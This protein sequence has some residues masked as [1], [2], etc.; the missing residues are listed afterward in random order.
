MPLLFKHYPSSESQIAVWHVQESTDE[1]RELLNDPTE[2]DALIS[3]I[4]LESRRSEK[5]AV[6]LLLQKML[7][8]E[9]S[10][11]SYDF[12]GRPTLIG[13]QEV[14]ISHSK[15]LVSVFLHKKKRIGLD[16]E[17]LRGLALRLYSKFA[18]DIEKE[19]IDLLKT[20]EER[21]FAACL[22]WSAKES[23]YKWYGRKKVSFKENL[24]VKLDVSQMRSGERSGTV[25]CIVRMEDA[26][27]KMVLD[28]FVFGQTV[29]TYC[30]QR[31]S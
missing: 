2:F 24:L 22:L 16:I 11:I 19:S 9:D 8:F 4:K 10:A 20:Q 31:S 21:E 5:L 17:H 27:E 29:L 12:Y 25:D 6:R 26:D 18:S 15:G 30:S 3:T 13:P 14:A 1:L 28:Y 23:L 7:P